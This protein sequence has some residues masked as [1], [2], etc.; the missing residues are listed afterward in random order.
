[1]RPSWASLSS[2]LEPSERYATAFASSK[3]I[4]PP[5]D[6]PVR[7]LPRMAAQLLMVTPR[8]V[9]MDTKS[10]PCS[11]ACAREYRCVC[12]HTSMRM[13]ACACVCEPVPEHVRLRVNV[14]VR[15]IMRMRT[16]KHVY[17]CATRRRTKQGVL[18]IV[19]FE[20]QVS[21]L[22]GQAAA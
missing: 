12:M 6:E 7:L 1:M 4:P 13:R 10:S 14:H 19:K 9:A 2:T 5:L 8:N 20:R 22:N 17:M 3:Y 16:E 11:C 18:L 15:A 21:A